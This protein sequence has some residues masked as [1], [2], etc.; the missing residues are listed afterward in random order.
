MGGIVSSLLRGRAFRASG[1]GRGPGCP[2]AGCRLHVVD[3]RR[4]VVATVSKSP[5]SSGL[6]K[7]SDR[8]DERS[9]WNLPRTGGGRHVSYKRTGLL[10]V[11]S[12]CCP[13]V[14]SWISGCGKIGI[15]GDPR[16]PSGPVHQGRTALVP[17]WPVTRI[18][19]CH[20]VF[21]HQVALRAV[22]PS[23]PHRVK[24]LTIRQRKRTSG[25]TDPYPSSR[26]RGACA[27]RPASGLQDHERPEVGSPAQPPSTS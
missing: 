1:E 17:R 4:Q 22:L 16:A 27:A 5:L 11:T 8:R 25:E 2:K 19:R 20:P 9:C 24:A 10:C 14:G 12:S 13:D 7:T 26:G 18:T 23:G 15:T 6:R 3:A 21:G